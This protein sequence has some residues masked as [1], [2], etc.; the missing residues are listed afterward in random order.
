MNVAVTKAGPTLDSRKEALGAGP[1]AAN[2]VCRMQRVVQR[3]K[4]DEKS[5]D[6]VDVTRDRHIAHVAVAVKVRTRA[7]TE[8]CRVA[9][10]APLGNA[11]AVCSGERD[12]A[13]RTLP[14]LRVGAV[15]LRNSTAYLT[16]RDDSHADGLLPLHGFSRVSFAAGG[17]CLVVTK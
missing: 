1:V 4:V 16:L 17:V 12:A 5:G 11:I 7:Q 10:I 2:A 15:T 13:T 3:R 8:R 14:P 6:R 9:L